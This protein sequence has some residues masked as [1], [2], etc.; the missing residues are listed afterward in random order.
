[1][2]LCYAFVAC[3]HICKLYSYIIISLAWLWFIVKLCIHVSSC[4]TKMQKKKLV[5]LTR[6]LLSAKVGGKMTFG[7]C[8]R[9]VFHGYLV[10]IIRRGRI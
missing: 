1:M 7:E 10:R 5:K 8:E 4:L 9:G 6:F 3:D 2:C